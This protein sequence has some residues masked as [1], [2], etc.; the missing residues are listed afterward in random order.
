MRVSIVL[1]VLLISVSLNSF[2]YGVGDSLIAK[3]QILKFTRDSLSVSKIDDSLKYSFVNRKAA[4]LISSGFNNPL[5]VFGIKFEDRIAPLHSRILLGAGFGYAA[6]TGFKTSFGANYFFRSERYKF[7]PLVGL[8]YVYAFGQ[9]LSDH[10][11]VIDFN[12]GSHQYLDAYIGIKIKPG[13]KWN[14]RVNDLHFRDFWDL[15]FIVGYSSLIS[16]VNF[17]EVHTPPSTWVYSY[18]TVKYYVEGGLI[19]GASFGIDIPHLK[20]YRIANG[21]NIYDVKQLH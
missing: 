6:I 5:G 21:H 8:D 9:Q 19:F 2:G 15:R 1:L 14:P 3:K 17:T 7:M 18:N 20:K 16:G 10:N 11:D 12:V 4:Y 13:A